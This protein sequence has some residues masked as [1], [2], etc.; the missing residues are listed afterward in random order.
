ME[1]PKKQAVINGG[2]AA[3]VT[4][5]LTWAIGLTGVQI[6]EEVYVAFATLISFII[7]WVTPEL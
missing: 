1:S 6:S 4:I 2:F 3:S 5:I 7:G